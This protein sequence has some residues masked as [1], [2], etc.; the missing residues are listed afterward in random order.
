MVRNGE[1]NGNPNPNHGDGAGCGILPV[2]A[3]KELWNAWNSTPN[4]DN[5]LAGWNDLA[6]AS[7]PPCDPESPW[8]GVYCNA[9]FNFSQSADANTS[10]WDLAIVGL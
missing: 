6:D 7:M 4:I 3:L 8:R 5:N 10:V 9:R 1:W 2:Y